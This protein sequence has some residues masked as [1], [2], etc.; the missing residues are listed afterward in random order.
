M[1]N[2]LKQLNNIDFDL[3]PIDLKNYYEHT[4][5]SY[6]FIDKKGQITK[7]IS[8]IMGEVDFPRLIEKYELN[9]DIVLAYKKMQKIP[10][11]RD[12]DYQKECLVSGAFLNLIAN[13]SRIKDTLICPSGYQSIFMEIKK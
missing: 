5:Q 7:G 13:E 3:T 1:K 8:S 2:Y 9:P 11:C 6:I 12:C 4:E 10:V